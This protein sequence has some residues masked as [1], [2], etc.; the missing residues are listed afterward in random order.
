MSTVGSALTTWEE[1]VQ[2]P[3]EAEGTHYELHDGE[4]VLVP[5]PKPLHVVIQIL[6]SDWFAAVA[7]GR[8]FVMCEFP[9]RPAT[10]LQYWVADVAYLPKEDLQAMRADEYHIYS[11]P[12]IIEVLS[13]SNRPAK[14]KRQRLVAFSAG[15]REFW[16]I[17][18]IRRTIEV[19]L[20]G[21]SSRIYTVEETIPVAVL[22]GALFP[23]RILFE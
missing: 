16:V 10:N 18:P 11:P 23:V 15:T 19:S 12:L 6:I 22:P 5:P 2:L 13:P 8:G 7:R 14:T 3:D 17:D 21:K 1:F 4:V 9:Y 20:P